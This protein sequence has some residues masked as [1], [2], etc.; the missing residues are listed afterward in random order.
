[1]AK[2]QIRHVRHEARKHEKRHLDLKD[3]LRKEILT[4]HLLSIFVSTFVIALSTVI[5]FFNWGKITSFFDKPEII[6]GP[7]TVEVVSGIHGFRTGALAVYQINGQAADQYIR[8]LQSIRTEGYRFG[9]VTANVFGT[10][11]EKMNE[12]TL[13]T[14][15]GSINVN[16]GI[17]RGKHLS[18]LAS[19]SAKMLQ[20]SILATYYLGEKT[21][22]IHS[23]IQTDSQ[24]LSKIKNTLEVDIFAYLNQST[25][26]ANSLDNFLKLI[27]TMIERATIRSTELQSQVTFLTSNYTAQDN[28]LELSEE[29]FFQNLKIFDGQDADKRLSE[30]IGLGQEQT[31]V[32]AKI[33]AYQGLKD[34]YDYFLPLLENLSRAIKLNR[35]PLIAGVKV[36]EV[37]NMTLKLI[38]PE[39]EE[40]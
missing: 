13:G 34:Y 11:E 6:E 3:L 18:K 28:S 31:E 40:Q 16:T 7:G 22:S 27:D 33:G 32:R 20:K 25:D 14:L 26:R 24:L 17:S 21:V 37:E 1:M 2:K 8:L 23:S 39:K 19:N 38:V 4:E 15:L 5:I 30:F 35:D 12:T 9:V 10:Q 36:V 29:A